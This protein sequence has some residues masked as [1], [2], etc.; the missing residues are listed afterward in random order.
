MTEASDAWMDDVGEAGFSDSDEEKVK[1]NTTASEEIAAEKSSIS[2]PMAQAPDAWMDDVGDARYSH[3]ENETEEEKKQIKE[4][5]T[6]AEAS[7]ISHP[8][9]E[10][11]AAGFEE[12]DFSDL[13][14]K[15]PLFKETS[16]SDLLV[17]NLSKDSFWLN[18]HTIDDA[19]DKLFQGKPKNKYTSKIKEVYDDNNE[20]DN[21]PSGHKKGQTNKE[22]DNI[23]SE[24]SANNLPDLEPSDFVWSDESTYLQPNIPVL[25]PLTFKMTS[26]TDGL[27]VESTVSK[28]ANSLSTIIKENV[29]ETNCKSFEELDLQKSSIQVALKL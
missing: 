22:T 11:H 26:M 9:T 25:K 8:E 17:E 23:D 19:E 4:L 21:D 24:S 16:K 28:S 12:E 27:H 1:E 2:L 6:V 29:I 5:D 13:E 15:E 20:D 14:M 10:A 18:K 3:S 7:T